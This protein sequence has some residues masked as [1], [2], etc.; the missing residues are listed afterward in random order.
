M[1]S[2]TATGLLKEA[3]RVGDQWGVLERQ[4]LGRRRRRGGVAISPPRLGPTS[5]CMRPDCRSPAC[6]APRRLVAV[7]VISY[8]T[9]LGVTGGGTVQLIRCLVGLQQPGPG[10]RSAGHPAV[11]LIPPHGGRHHHQTADEAIHDPRRQTPD[12]R[13][14]RRRGREAG[15]SPRCPTSSRRPPARPNPGRHTSS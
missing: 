4:R 11:T 13:L 7:S 2:S 15:H 10:R 5:G 1:A 3:H 6:F 9:V 8:G 12:H 14:K